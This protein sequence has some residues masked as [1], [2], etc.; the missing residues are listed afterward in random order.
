VHI[1]SNKLEQS[2]HFWV[3]SDCG[4]LNP[5]PNYPDD[6]NSIS[7]IITIGKDMG[8]K[9]PDKSW[10]L[11]L[12][13]FFIGPKLKKHIPI[14]LDLTCAFNNDGKFDAIFGGHNQYQFKNV[15]PTVGHSYVREIIANPIARK[16]VYDLTD[17][18]TG[19]HESFELE[20]EKIKGIDEILKWFGLD[21]IE[22][23]EFKGSGHFTGI[24]WW[25]L[26]EQ[27]PYPIRYE[28]MISLL[29]YGILNRENPRQYASYYPYNS[30]VPDKDQNSK[31]YPISFENSRIMR[32]CICYNITYGDSG[33]GLTY[34][35]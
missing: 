20:E 4:V 3:G 6:V 13:E 21:T 34:S 29:Q 1:R 35:F 12:F 5:K 30:L 23:I 24:E 28:V 7:D 22:E 27:N 33:T 18:N 25:N 32:G 14:E 15:F 16:I 10:M 19:V 31:R 17:M 26:I 9:I 2:N 11:Y 8:N